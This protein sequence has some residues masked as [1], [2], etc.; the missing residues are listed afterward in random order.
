MQIKTSEEKKKNPQWDTTSHLPEWL[1]LK[2]NNERGEDKGKRDPLYTAAMKLKDACSL[3]G[4][5]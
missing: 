4:N 1:L 3:E 2:R 5:L